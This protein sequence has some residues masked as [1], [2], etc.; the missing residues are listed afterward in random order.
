MSVTVGSV[1]VVITDYQPK[2]RRTLD[3]KN[4]LSDAS[5]TSSNASNDIHEERT[6]SIGESLT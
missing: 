5:D 4:T 1:T 2:K 6:H 3:Q